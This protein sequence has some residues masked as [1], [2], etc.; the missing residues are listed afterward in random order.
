MFA[1]GSWLDVCPLG[2]YNMYVV[3]IINPYIHIYIYTHTH[4]HIY[5]HTTTLTNML[6][7]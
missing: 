7:C 4:I 6:L 2:V 5:I 3:P 1:L